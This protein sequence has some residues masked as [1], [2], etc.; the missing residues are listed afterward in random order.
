MPDSPLIDRRH[1]DF[2]LHALCRV[3]EMLAWPRFAHL[4]RAALD[5][6]VDAAHALALAKFA[7]HA[8][9]G[10]VE[11]PHVVDGRVR[12]VPE[13][14]EALQAHADAGFPA[15]L[16][17]L[18]DGG[19]QLPYA[20]ALACDGLFCAANVATAG[21]AL[22]ARGVA[23][24]LTSFGTPAQRARFVPALLEGRHFGTMCLSEPQAGSSLADVATRA[25]PHGDGTWRV[26]GAKMWISGGEHE[27]GGNIVHL[28]LARTPDAPPGVRGLSLFVVPRMRDDGTANDVR[29]AGL[30]HKLGQR[31]IVNTVL[32]F[33]DADDCVGELVGREGEGLAQMFQLMNEARLGVG[34]GAVMLASAGYRAALAY[35]RE[36][37]QGRHPDQ[38]DARAA[39]VAIV[40]HAD[41][42]RMLLRQK[43]IS[44]GGFA[45]ALETAR[46]VDV[47]AHAPGADA[48][49]DAGLLL[50]FLTPVVKAWSGHWGCVANDLAIQ[51]HGGYGYTREF[52]VEQLWRDNRL[53]PIHEG[54][55]GIQA[56]DLLGRKLVQAEGAGLRLLLARIETTVA[57]A[58]AQATLAA[59]AQALASAA[60][61]LARTSGVLG[62]ALAQG[63]ARVALANASLYLD[64]VGHVAV[65][66]AW[67]R[68]A[69]L[70]QHELEA[71]R[72]DADFLRGKLA[73][74]R[75]WFAHELPPVLAH[76]PLLESLDDAT[77][78][79]RAD[80]L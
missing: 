9:R 12:L 80:W 64:L 44:E 68:M 65:A 17:D 47:Q 69:T 21:Y 45:L 70:A 29:L 19:L 43:A 15:M 55:N 77:V 11:E 59:H 49:R 5:A 18:D 24:V 2:V 61:G 33:G 10:D 79:L 50:D 48:R 23:N 25:R 56:I 3:D 71:G 38:R 36:R 8:R 20:V 6:V 58:C 40:D 51:V 34:M 22:L 63:R 39:P 4:D 78:E 35:A 32:A 26:R 52:A 1:L 28:V 66:D 57:Q 37:R 46:L 67:L 13:V 62:A 16:A 31:G 75:H 60:Q 73:A 41:V 27:L 14:R 54:A 53:N 76:V 30:N 42:R 74:C 7:N 72:G